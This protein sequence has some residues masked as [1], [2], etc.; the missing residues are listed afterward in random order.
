MKY[1]MLVLREQ[2]IRRLE[3]A[4]EREEIQREEIMR[5]TADAQTRRTLTPSCC[6]Q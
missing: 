3:E 5:R 1:K 4:E 6:P 2:S